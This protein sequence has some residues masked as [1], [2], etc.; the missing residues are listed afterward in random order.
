MYYFAVVCSDSLFDKTS[1]LHRFFSK[2]F[3]FYLLDVAALDFSFFRAYEFHVI[4]I[5]NHNS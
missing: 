5:L 4:L 1:N 3:L 2:R